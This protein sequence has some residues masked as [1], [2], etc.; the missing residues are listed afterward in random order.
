MTHP[1]P[2]L[3]SPDALEALPLPVFALDGRYHLEPLNGAAMAL[4]E[5]GRV[6]TRSV[7]ATE[8]PEGRLLCPLIDRALSGETLVQHEAVWPN[9]LM[10]VSLWAAPYGA[11]ALLALDL[12][13]AAHPHAAASES[14]ALM[15]AMLAHE[16]RNPLLAITGAAQLLAG[17]GAQPALCELI[18][19]E[20]AR[21]E[22]LLKEMDPLRG[23]RDAE[24]KPI[25][26]HELLDQAIDSVAAGIAP[27]IR[28]ARVYDPSLPA[29]SGDK[30][31]LNRV[32]TNL[33]KNAAEAC[34][35]VAQP[36]ITL[37][38]RFHRSAGGPAIAIDIADNGPGI[39]EAMAAQ[40]F[41]PFVT[42][43]QG[44]RGLGLTIAL[45]ITQDHGGEIALT[46]RKRGA[47]S[48]RVLLPLSPLPLGDA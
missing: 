20:G 43:K 13:G 31:S 7:L 10:H 6:F 9:S 1:A 17:A 37:T 41:R 44:G 27:H 40:L 28:I 36:E 3:P 11:R 34:L 48:F 14:A 39:E 19:R 24:R 42:G 4:M 23:A 21:I 29:I 33:I 30:D 2:S 8:E 46:S 22:R 47:T 25:N 16:I 18:A 45:R 5:S 12:K 35:G 32:F 26:I 15:A 38:T